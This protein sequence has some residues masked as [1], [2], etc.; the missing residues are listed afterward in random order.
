MNETKK[1]QCKQIIDYINRYGSITVREASDHL[2][3]N[4]P[5]KRLSEIQRNGYTIKKTW[6]ERINLLGEKKRYIRYSFAEV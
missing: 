2:D 1:T 3:I 4:S 5:T 6:E